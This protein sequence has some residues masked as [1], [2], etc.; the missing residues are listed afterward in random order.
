MDS[1]GP[2]LLLD[3]VGRSVETLATSQ[4]GPIAADRQVLGEARAEAAEDPPET[5]EIQHHVNFNWRRRWR[6]RGVCNDFIDVIT[7]R[8]SNTPPEGWGDQAIYLPPSPRTI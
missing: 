3:E 8:S 4:D 5:A 6:R 7:D 2:R 1:F